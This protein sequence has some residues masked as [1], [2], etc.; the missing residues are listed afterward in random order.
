MEHLTAVNGIAGEDRDRRDA[1]EVRD[2]RE[3]AQFDSWIR[4]P[5]YPD[6]FGLGG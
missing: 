1:L 6:P 4:Q 5:E 2:R 3:L